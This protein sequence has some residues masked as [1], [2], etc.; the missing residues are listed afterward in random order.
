MKLCY[1]NYR[2]DLY[3]IECKEKIFIGQKYIIVDEYYMGEVIEKYYHV[4]HAPVV[5]ETDEIYISE[6][7]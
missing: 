7:E 5:D 6:N 1:N 2:E 3:C 4:N